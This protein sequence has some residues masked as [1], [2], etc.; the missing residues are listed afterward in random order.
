[1]GIIRLFIVFIHDF[2]DFLSAFSLQLCLHIPDKL[3]QIRNMVISAYPKDMKFA[4]P[5]AL[6]TRD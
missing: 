4:N 1:M 3:I 6:K 5:S 2:Q